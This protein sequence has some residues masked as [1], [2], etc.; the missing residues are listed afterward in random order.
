LYKNT[1]FVGI[2]ILFDESEIRENLYGTTF[3]EQDG[4]YLAGLV[5]GSLTYKYFNRHPFLNEVNRV[6]IILGKNNP[7][8]NSYKLGFYSGVKKVNPPCEIIEINLN[9]L[10]NEEKGS[11]AVSELKGK[12]VDIVFTV[13]GNSDI[14]VFKSAIESDILVIA[15]NKD[16]GGLNNTLTSIEKKI[17]VTSYLM[18]K[19]I[20]A[21]EYSTGSNVVFGLKEGGI[22]LAPYYNFDKYIPKDL[23]VL[24]K[25]KTEKL[26]K[27]SEII[28]LTIEE[29]EFDPEDIPEIE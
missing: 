27:G 14:G 21:G 1:T 2:D 8:I 9:D 11:D 23:N 25:N 13:S 16:Q 7:E 18:T 22:S 19:K 17:S 12:G 24:I 10:D 5:A 29:I 28:P 3:K 20:T 4:G 15:V 26:I 6:G